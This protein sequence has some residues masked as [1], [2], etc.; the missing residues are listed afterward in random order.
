[1][2]HHIYCPFL[3]RRPFWHLLACF[4]SRCSLNVSSVDPSTALKNIVDSLKRKGWARHH[5]PRPSLG[6]CICNPMGIW[7]LTLAGFRGPCPGFLAPLANNGELSAGRC[8][9]SAPAPT[10]V[11]NLLPP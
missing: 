2:P 10:L 11:T 9:P 3:F 7:L 8:H 5:V 6:Y 1:M 4:R